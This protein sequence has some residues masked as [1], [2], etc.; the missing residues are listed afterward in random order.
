MQKCVKNL[1]IRRLYC[2]LLLFFFITTCNDEIYNTKFKIVLN[3]LNQ[4]DEARTR[5]NALKGI[6][7]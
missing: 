2:I 3:P 1:L 4:A 7:Y 6:G 5:D